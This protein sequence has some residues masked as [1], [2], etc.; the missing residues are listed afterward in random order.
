MVTVSIFSLEQKIK[1]IEIYNENGLVE[2]K[3]QTT[4][5]QIT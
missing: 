3:N 4:S 1:F 2:K 5:T